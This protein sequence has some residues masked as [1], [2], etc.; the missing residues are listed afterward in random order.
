MGRSIRHFEYG[1]TV[2]EKFRSAILNSHGDEPRHRAADAGSFGVPRTGRRNQT[3]IA[4]IT[5]RQ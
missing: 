4:A 2:G 1:S 5:T 3:F